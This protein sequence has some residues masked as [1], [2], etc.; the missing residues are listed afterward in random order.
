MCFTSASAQSDQTQTSSTRST[1]ATEHD[2]QVS[3]LRVDF[4][5]H[6]I[7]ASEF[8]LIV[9]APNVCTSH[10][11]HFGVFICII[12]NLR[13]DGIFLSPIHCLTVSRLEKRPSSSPSSVY[14]PVDTYLP[15]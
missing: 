2:E 8:A 14:H 5:G 9:D 4:A 13:L 7:S 11:H 10:Q 3:F 12:R 15:Q 6:K 1:R